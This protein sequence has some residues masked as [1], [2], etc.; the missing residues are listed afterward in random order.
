MGLDGDSYA[1]RELFHELDLEH[2]KQDPFPQRIA[3]E[4][5]GTRVHGSSLPCTGKLH[6]L[7]LLDEYILICAAV[8]PESPASNAARS[9]GTSIV[10]AIQ[11]TASVLVEE[12]SVKLTNQNILD[13]ISFS[14]ADEILGIAGPNGSG[15]STLL[16]TIE[17][18][19]W[20]KHAGVTLLG[21]AHT[22][23]PRVGYLPQT[24]RMPRD[25]TVR[26]FVE[27]AAW[28]KRA[29]TGGAGIDRAMVAARLEE[30]AD[31]KI[32]KVSGGVAQRAGFASVLVDDPDI[33]L[34]DEPTSGVDIRQRDF[35]RTAI[36]A[37]RQG[38]VTILSSHII[39]DLEQ[40]CDRV[41]VLVGGRVVFLGTPGEACSRTA[42]RTFSEALLELTG[43]PQ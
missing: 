21:R 30:F 20:R 43:K 17:S 11:L 39:E 25:L 38:R 7:S 2:P 28:I 6:W 26:Q 27:Y 12:L 19:A 10:E 1:Q 40:L 42:R 16:S 32:G 24:F 3:I 36:S 8:H 4:D 41:L 22:S 5:P 34:L 29:K 14:A 35:M 13:S 23:S 33:L 37:Q 9:P 18:A 31:H 15:K